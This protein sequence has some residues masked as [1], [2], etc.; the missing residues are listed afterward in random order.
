VLDTYI[1]H[2]RDKLD[3][4]G[5]P[6]LIQTVRGVGYVLRT[7]DSRANTARPAGQQAAGQTGGAAQ[8]SQRV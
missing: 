8:Q 4:P 5:S 2:L 1:H 7:P 6:Q 3:Q